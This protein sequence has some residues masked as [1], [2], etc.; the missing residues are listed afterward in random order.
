[1]IVCFLVLYGYLAV[2]TAYVAVDHPHP[3][4]AA[5]VTFAVGPVLCFW[6][7]VTMVICTLIVIL[8]RL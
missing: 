1:M 6:V 3:F 2:V 7:A 8:R 4:L 5:A